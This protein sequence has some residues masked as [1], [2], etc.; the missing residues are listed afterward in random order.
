MDKSDNK[1]G[2][3]LKSLKRGIKLFIL[4]SLAGFTFIYFFNGT[5][6]GK[7]VLFH[8]EMKYF[9]ILFLLVL[10]D[11][12]LGA[13][14][15]WIFARRASVPISFFGCLKANSATI[16]VGAVTPFQ[17]G[18]GA[19]QVYML[20][21]EGLPIL[22]GIAVSSYGYLFS[23][24]FIMISGM[25]A[26]M[27]IGEQ[28]LGPALSQLFLYGMFLI[29]AVIL[30]IGISLLRPIILGT[31]LRVL[32]K[33]VNFFISSE[34]INI[35]NEKIID[36]IHTLKNTFFAVAKKS[37]FAVFLSFILS[38][39]VYLNKFTIAFVVIHSLGIQTEYFY[40]IKIQSILTSMYYLMPTPGGSGIAEVASAELLNKII[41]LSLM[42]AYT[43][44]WRA[45]ILYIGM[46]F[47][48]AIL[49]RELSKNQ[50]EKSNSTE[51]AVT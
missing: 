43:F 18:G 11:L 19:G 45:F 7:D 31:I 46:A 3:N 42:A 16:F 8:I 38:S 48:G 44:I 28:L 15:L 12:I 27:T 9:V 29:G 32:G 10:F 36:E 14:R 47:G 2:I 39:L 26:V 24:I 22:E 25:Y 20:Y 49:F 4:A 1:N 33:A 13:M 17:S 30:L 21:S 41:P 5:E 23:M 35:F 37:P 51:P 34:R 50:E 6:N 40:T